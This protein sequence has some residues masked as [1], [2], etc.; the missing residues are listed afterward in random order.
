MCLLCGDA[1]IRSH[2][3]SIAERP[4][5]LLAGKSW[6]GSYGAA[7]DG[8]TLAVLE[9][10]QQF[11]AQRAS[12]WKSPIVAL[13]RSER[14]GFFDYF[15]GIAVEEGEAL[16]ADF[17][18]YDLP[19]MT[20]ASS[21]HGQSDGDVV[22]HYDAILDW[23]RG[24]GYARDRSLYDHREEYPHDGNLRDDKPSLRLMLPVVLEVAKPKKS[25]FSATSD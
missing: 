5:Q 17:V 16:P 22:T 24:S 2:S 1:T 4:A 25:Q 11:S 18:F 7:A 15:A 8:A 14:E 19:E 6:S 23:L 20:V 13:S 3:I 12:A 9:A 21:W 10:V